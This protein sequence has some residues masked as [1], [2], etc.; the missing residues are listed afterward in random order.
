MSDDEILER[1]FGMTEDEKGLLRSDE[2]DLKDRF[3]VALVVGRGRLCEMQTRRIAD[4]ME[5]DL[6]DDQA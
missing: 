4:Q 3:L 2:L 1:Y 6:A 5:E